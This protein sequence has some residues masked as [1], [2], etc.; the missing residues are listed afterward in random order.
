M[1]AVSGWNLEAGPKTQVDELVKKK[2]HKSKSSK[3]ASSSNA[4]LITNQRFPISEAEPAKE[5]PKPKAEKQTVVTPENVLALYEKVIEGKKP[6]KKPRDRKRSK[7]SAKADP[8]E[9][10]SPTT[11][12]KRSKPHDEEDGEGVAPKTIKD[13]REGNSAQNDNQTVPQK[14]K[15][16]TRGEMNNAKTASTTANTG[17]Q[18]DSADKTPGSAPI[19]T[20]TPLQQKMRQK[21]SSARFRHINEILYATPSD[22]SLN[23]FR[24]QPEMYQEYHTGF[25]RQVEVW[26]E[27]PVDVFIKQLQERGKVKFE[28]GHNK[29]W[30]SNAGGNLLPLPRDK[31]EGWCTVTD[32]GCGDAKIAATINYQK[33]RGKAKVKIL[34]YDLQ[35]STPDVTVADIAHLPLES[36][37]VDVAIF[38]LALMGTNFLDFIEEAYRILRWRGELW[39]AEI[40]S[41]FNRP[42]ANEAE[43]DAETEEGLKKGDEPYKPFVDA[44]SKRGFT[45]RG[46][47]DAGNKMFVRME[48]VK[49]QEKA[50]RD[51][52]D[53]ESWKPKEKK[54]KFVE[55]DE[56]R[57]DQILKPCVYKLR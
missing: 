38:C 47:V 9:D 22:S 19:S 45:L 20:L 3:S 23:L 11:A 1:F 14:K 7:K 50:K 39:V 41:R 44:L 17:A 57:E 12:Q 37:S 21:L 35:A 27:N 42:S 36:E 49:M 16:K 13:A 55:N 6:A 5:I 28:R 30:N 40:K 34:S 29:K 24:E 15:K 56:V 53:G 18:S 25:R 4:T 46:T 10:P 8:L 48:F 2:K 31:E 52:G 26:P 33:P 32:L 54:L 51:D 43:D